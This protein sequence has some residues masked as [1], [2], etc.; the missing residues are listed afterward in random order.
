MAWTVTP[1]AKEKKV[2]QYP[3]FGNFGNLELTL[4]WLEKKCSQR[5]NLGGGGKEGS[6][7]RGTTGK[8]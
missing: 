8:F 6:V 7:N 4:P 5:T 1:G 2:G 3:G